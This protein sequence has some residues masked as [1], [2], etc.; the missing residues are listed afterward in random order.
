V[1][2][3]AILGQNKDNDNSDYVDTKIEQEEDDEDDAQD[4][5]DD[6]PQKEEDEDKGALAGSFVATFLM[7]QL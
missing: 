3:I 1:A 7:Q 4:D 2:T 6:E 5:D